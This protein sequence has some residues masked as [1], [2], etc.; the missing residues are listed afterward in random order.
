MHGTR[1]LLQTLSCGTVK[2]WHHS[3]DH[4]CDG[5]QHSASSPELSYP[6]H[7]VVPDYT[8][9]TCEP[10]IARYAVIF[11]AQLLD[12]GVNP[13]LPDR[14]MTRCVEQL[15]LTLLLCT[16]HRQLTLRRLDVLGPVSVVRIAGE[17]LLRVSD[18]RVVVGRRHAGSG[19]EH[20]FQHAVAADAC[21]EPDL[22]RAPR[23]VELDGGRPHEPRVW[24][25]LHREAVCDEAA[26]SLANCLTGF[27]SQ[28]H[29]ASC[30]SIKVAA[31]VFSV[32]EKQKF[33]E[34]ANVLI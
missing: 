20:R 22:H 4:A 23:G 26:H 5:P 2:G 34:N 14:D 19:V 7:Q 30:F 18:G 25:R 16:T 31:I 12:A 28:I 29:F 3:T 10:W 1:G 21:E 24:R 15:L 17:H 33:Q 9:N 13:R 8:G 27:S 11:L 32:A 6:S